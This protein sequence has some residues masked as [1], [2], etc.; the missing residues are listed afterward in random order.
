ML[1][2]LLGQ[3]GTARLDDATLVEHMDI[4]RA[5]HLQ[6]PVV[7]GD[8]DARRL[9][10]LQLVDALGYDTHGI[11]VQTGVRL[12][13]DAQLGLQHRHLEDFI[14]FLLA[15]AEALVD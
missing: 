12:V 1:L 11:D 2:N 9:G 5:N 3:F 14:A 15:T 13:E 6:Q 4:L 10:G 8:D 7:V